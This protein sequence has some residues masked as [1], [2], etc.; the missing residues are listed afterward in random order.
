[1]ILYIFNLLYCARKQP[2]LKVISLVLKTETQATWFSFP[3]I[4]LLSQLHTVLK[5]K[6]PFFNCEYQTPLTFILLLLPW[7]VKKLIY[8][9]LFY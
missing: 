9:I 7:N 4:F 2:F 8:N 3:A 6:V 1:M 5:T